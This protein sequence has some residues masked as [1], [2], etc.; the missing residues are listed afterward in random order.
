MLRTL[1]LLLTFSFG[2]ASTAQAEQASMTEAE[3]AAVQL[4]LNRG[5]D[6][7]RYD[8][9]AWQTADTLREDIPNLEDSGIRGW[10]VTPTENGLQT[11]YWKKNGE[12]FAGVYSAVWTGKSVTQRRVL[13]ANDTQL[14]AQQ[15]DLILAKEAIDVKA[16]ENCSNRPFNTVV[17][18]SE[19]AGDPILV[20]F[21][22]PQ[23]R[24]SAV[25]MGG[26][27]RFSVVDGK[28]RDQRAFTKSCIELGLTDPKSQNGKAEALVIGHLL[29]P[30]PTEIHVFSTFTAKV[31]I[32]VSTISN[33]ALWVTEISGGQPRVRLIKKK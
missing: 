29:D 4:A 33:E 8:Q 21:L 12:G 31:P 5:L 1:I 24:L 11:T 10:V 32:Y 15:L 14:S 6:L 2:I 19:K 16:L 9:A 20:Y 25:P 28:V 23:T 17:L 30:E 13:A 3:A 7:Y 22:T 26:H 18:P 27:Y